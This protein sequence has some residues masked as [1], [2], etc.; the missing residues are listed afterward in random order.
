MHHLLQ[1]ID[2]AAEGSVPTVL[3]TGGVPYKNLLLVEVLTC[4]HSLS[5]FHDVQ[6]SYEVKAPYAIMLRG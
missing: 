3:T 1:A 2:G 4:H 5:C 6:L